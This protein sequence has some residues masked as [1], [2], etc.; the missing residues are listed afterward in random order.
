MPTVSVE[1]ATKRGVVPAQ[2][3]A[4]EDDVFPL[5]RAQRHRPAVITPPRKL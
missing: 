1:I 2:S 3:G 5:A 4:R